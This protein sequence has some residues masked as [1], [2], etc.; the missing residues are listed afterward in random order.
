MA[1]HFPSCVLLHF[2]VALHF[3]FPLGFDFRLRFE[4]SLPRDVVL[5]LQFVEAPGILDVGR[6]FEPEVMGAVD[7][8]R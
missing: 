4:F 8:A 7:I 6:T 2:H 5:Y 3:D 1:H